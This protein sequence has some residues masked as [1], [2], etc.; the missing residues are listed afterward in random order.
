M[1][2]WTRLTEPFPDSE[3]KQRPGSA[4]YDHK[5]NCDGPRC[6]QTKDPNAHIQFS[7]VDAR[8]VA[9]RLD[10]VLGQIGWDF[11]CEVSASNVV[12]G[13]LVIYDG[14][15]QVVREDHGYPNSDNDDEPI[16]AATS[17]ALKRCAVL[18][19]IGR[20]LYEDNKPQTRSAPPQRPAA[21][22]QS[23]PAPM[24]P[25][26]VDS[27]P[28]EPEDLFAPREEFAPLGSPETAV[29]ASD[30]PIHRVPWAGAPGDYWHKDPEGKYCRHPDNIKRPRR[31]S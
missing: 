3:V 17:D 28:E 18:F 5:P 2:D 13:R 31:A 24:R 19:G 16:K 26:V 1:A 11:T 20:H 6:R 22:T 12:K 15:R 4:K 27:V 9:H 29:A 30:C 25:S 7:Y 8:V 23:R 21:P 14:P 10:E